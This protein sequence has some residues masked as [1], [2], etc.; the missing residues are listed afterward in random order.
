MSKLKHEQGSTDL[1]PSAL[2]GLT[3]LG[4]AEVNHSAG[5]LPKFVDDA[6]ILFSAGPG[7]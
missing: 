5:V 2:A 1:F 3:P 6:T 4:R 7:M